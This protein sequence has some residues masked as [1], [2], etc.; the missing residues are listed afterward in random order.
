MKHTFSVQNNKLD[1]EYVD[2]G[3]D[4]VFN[5]ISKYNLSVDFQP[6]QKKE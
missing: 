2:N 5:N 6:A 1:E 4:K 3:K